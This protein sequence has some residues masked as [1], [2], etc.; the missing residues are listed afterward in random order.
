M[1]ESRP[2]RPLVV[3]TYLYGTSS[4]SATLP[5]SARNTDFASLR[6]TSNTTSCPNTSTLTLKNP[7]I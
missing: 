1:H 7:G 5:P 3:S 6:P 2:D 4:T